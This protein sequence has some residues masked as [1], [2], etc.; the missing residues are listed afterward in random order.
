M[1]NNNVEVEKEEVVEDTKITENKTE[2]KSEEEMVLEENSKLENYEEVHKIFTDILTSVETR[3]LETVPEDGELLKMGKTLM[4]NIVEYGDK[5]DINILYKTLNNSFEYLATFFYTFNQAVIPEER[6]Y[7]GILTKKIDI[8][9]FDLIGDKETIEKQY[10]LFSNNF[11]EGN[12]E[13][14]IKIMLNPIAFNLSNISTI[15]A[16]IK[17]IIFYLE[18]DLQ[19]NLKDI[20]NNIL[21]A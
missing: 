7:L 5:D 6:T 3:K 19:L 9:L 13:M 16:C 12:H 4:E 8:I 20:L 10:N 21:E 14:N 11:V 1:D 15:I 18:K 2:V 17:T